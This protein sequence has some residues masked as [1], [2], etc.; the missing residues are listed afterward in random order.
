MLLIGTT[1]YEMLRLL[2][3]SDLIAGPNMRHSVNLP[4]IIVATTGRELTCD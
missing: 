1:I 2:D 4:R 3:Q